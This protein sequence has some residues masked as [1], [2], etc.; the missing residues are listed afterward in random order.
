MEGGATLAA[1]LNASPR[2]IP[3]ERFSVAG[4]ADKHGL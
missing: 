2:E 3:A 1:S 4:L